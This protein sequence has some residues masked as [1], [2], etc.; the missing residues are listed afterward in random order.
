MTTTFASKKSEL[1]KAAEAMARES[2]L[3]E[4]NS[5]TFSSVEACAKVGSGDPAFAEYR[6][7]ETVGSGERHTTG[8]NLDRAP[9]LGRRINAETLTAKRAALAA[10][11]KQIASM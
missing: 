2:V 4:T 7:Y 5:G 11:K 8:C 9:G 1:I 6:I 10:I 3:I